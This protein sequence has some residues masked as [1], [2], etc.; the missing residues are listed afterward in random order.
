MAVRPKVVI[1]GAGFGGLSATRALRRAP[2]QV[3]L[4]DA[5]NFH[6]FQPLLYQVATAGL[7]SDDIAYPVRG[8]LRRQRNARFRLGRLSSVDL[9]RRLV[10]L[11]DGG[12]LPYDWLVLAIGA[13]SASFGVVGVAE[14]ALGLKSLRDANRLRAHLLQRVEAADVAAAGSV[15][16]DPADLSVVIVGGGPTGVELA[17]GIRELFD[18]VLAR[19]FPHLELPRARIT[20]VEATDRVLGTFAPRLSAKAERALARRGIELE[21]GTGVERIEHGAVVLADGRRLEGGTI[22]WA[23]GVRA[24]PIAAGIG[25]P[26]GRGGRVHVAADLSL[27]ERPEVFAVGDVAGSAGQDGAPLP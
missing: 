12:T 17:G 18:K 6:L 15:A 3:T 16:T 11:D 10:H 14:H 20:L 7:D 24:N 25:L 9:N 19:D 2:V 27:V 5:N 26:T 23:A 22:V 21:L 8:I 13:V 1:V 4:V